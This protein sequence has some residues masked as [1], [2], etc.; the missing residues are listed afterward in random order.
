MTELIEEFFAK[1]RE[2]SDLEKLLGIVDKYEPSNVQV[3]YDYT[4]A[5]VNYIKYV[6]RLFI[7]L[8]IFA[9]VYRIVRQ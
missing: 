5:N 1:K 3:W 6:T 7:I 8:I 9:V 2:K 4:P